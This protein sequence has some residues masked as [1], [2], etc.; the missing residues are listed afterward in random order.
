MES[1]T[2]KIQTFV[3]HEP[4]ISSEIYNHFSKIPR[5]TVKASVSKMVRHGMLYRAKLNLQHNDSIVFRYSQ[6]EDARLLSK[7]Y[8][9]QFYGRTSIRLLLELMQTSQSSVSLPDIAKLAVLRVG[10]APK[11]EWLESIALIEA[12]E[13]LGYV[14]SIES[15][16]DK[17]RWVLNKDLFV[18]AKLKFN[19]S[20]L[21]PNYISLVDTMKKNTAEALSQWLIQN[22]FVSPGG[23]Q[24]ISNTQS[25]VS[26]AYLPFDFLGFCFSG[27]IVLRKKGKKLIPKPMVGDVLFDVCSLPYAK[28][29][30]ARI[31]EATAV[32]KGHVPIGFILAKGFS[33]DAFQ[34]L[35]REGVF[36][37]AIDQL[38]GTKT[39]ESIQK[40]LLICEKLIRKADVDPKLFFEAFS[41]LENFG[42]LFGNI[43][44]KLFEIMMAYLL[45]RQG[46]ENVE[47]ARN[48]PPN[49]KRQFDENGIKIPDLDLDVYGNLGSEAIFLECKA[50]A[51]NIVV[52]DGEIEKHFLERTPRMRDFLI[53]IPQNKLR[54]FKSIIVTSGGFSEATKKA[55]ANGDYKPRSDTVFELWDRNKLRDLFRYGGQSDLVEVLDR[56]FISNVAEVKPQTCVV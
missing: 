52:E 18:K 53:A 28:S 47:L 36:T 42:G 17:T 35:T 31:D 50:C 46:Y 9:N 56:F 5:T 24:Y 22:R 23:S 12:L 20:N 3:A 14:K 15:R 45:T 33:H 54:N 27:G 21:H 41:G 38:F 7:L 26:F 10:I 51:E 16:T 13:E 29:F 37:W 32:S 6:F 25:V 11:F 1:L 8:N 44:G 49:R 40:T 48:V 19:S 39:A 4:R 2:K 55:F 30:K 34:Y 43:K